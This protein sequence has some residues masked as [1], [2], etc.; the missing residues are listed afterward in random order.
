MD[1]FTYVCQTKVYFGEGC[2]KEALSVELGKYGPTV[3][4]AYGGGSIKKNGIY[5]EICRLLLQAGK[6]IWS[7]P[8]LCQIPHIEK[9]KKVQL[10]FGNIMWT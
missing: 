7:F 9:C 10:L 8:V 6:N 3:M 1:K 4:L 5:D 2:L